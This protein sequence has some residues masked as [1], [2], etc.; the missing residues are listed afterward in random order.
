[1]LEASPIAM[2][3]DLQLPGASGLD[4]QRRLRSEGSM[5]P[6]IVITAD[7]QARNRDEA[8]RFGCPAYL[9]KPCEGATT[10]RLLRSIPT[11]APARSRPDE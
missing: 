2:L 11:A 6:I 8:N 1:M 5:L 10:L 7:D 9:L 3:F 4:L